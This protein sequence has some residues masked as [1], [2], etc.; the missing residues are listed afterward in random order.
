MGLLIVFLHR[1]VLVVPHMTVLASLAAMV[2]SRQDEKANSTTFVGSMAAEVAAWDSNMQ[3]LEKQVLGTCFGVQAAK[4]FL[5]HM[6]DP[7]AQH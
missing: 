1:A 3:G 5:M 2:G 4:A 7:Q 6:M